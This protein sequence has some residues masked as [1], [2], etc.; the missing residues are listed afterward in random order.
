MPRAL[1]GGSGQALLPSFM[2]V[3]AAGF[4]VI[5]GLDTAIWP[6]DLLRPEKW[7]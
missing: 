4:A 7:V 2:F 5:G 3:V 1:L 6:C